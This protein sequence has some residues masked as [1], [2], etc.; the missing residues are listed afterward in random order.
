MSLDAIFLIGFMLLNLLVGILSSG[1]VKNM[2]EYAIGNRTFPTAVIVATIVATRIGGGDFSA[3]AAQSY[4]EGM[5]FILAAASGE[6][7][8]FLLIGYYLVPRMAEFFGMFTTAEILGNLYG[9]RVRMISSLCMMFLSLGVLA[10]QLKVS[11]GLLT[12]F[13]DI[14]SK[15][16]ILMVGTIVILYSAFGGIRAVTITDVLQFFTFGALLPIVSFVLWGTLGNP[17]VVVESIRHNDNYSLSRIF[18]LGNPKFYEMIMLFLLYL[19]PG[20]DVTMFQRF[21]MAQS[22]MQARRAFITSAMV[23]FFI[24]ALVSWIGTLLSVH[25]TDV[26]DQNIVGILIDNYGSEY[27]KV[28]VILGIMAMIMSTADSYMNAGSVVFVNDFCTSIGVKVPENRKIVV[29]KT[30]SVV[31]GICGIA[32]AFQEHGVFELLLLINSFSMPIDWV[33]L[34]L[35]IIGFRSSTRCVLIGMA[36]GLGTVASW[37]YIFPETQIAN[38]IPGVIA[39][40][41]FYIGSHYLF[42]EKGG[43]IGVRDRSCLDL[44]EAESKKS[45]VHDHWWQYITNFSFVRFCQKNTPKQD[46]IY[47]LLG[48]FSII[49]IFSSIYTVPHHIEVL[50]ADVME[51]IYN[52]VLVLSILMI[53]YP[54]WPDKLKNHEIS[55]VFRVCTVCYALVIAPSVLVF[56][57]NFGHLQAMIF[58]VNII[59]IAVVFNWRIVL[60]MIIIGL[61]CSIQWAKYQPDIAYNIDMGSVQLNIAYVAILL[62][63]IFVVLIRPKQEYR[64]VIETEVI[65]RTSQL[66]EALEEKNEFLNNMSHEI[67]TPL[68]SFTSI[69]SGLKEQWGSLDEEKKLYYAQQ[70][71]NSAKRLNSLIWSVL[72]LARFRSDTVTLEYSTFDF[73]ELV[74]ETLESVKGMGANEKHL[75]WKLSRDNSVVLEADKDSIKQ[76]LVHLLMNAIKFTKPSTTITVSVGFGEVDVGGS[77]VRAVHLSVADEGPGVPDEELEIIFQAFVQ[78]SRTKTKAGGIGLGLNLCKEIITAHHGAIWAEN[79]KGGVGATF[80][81]LVPLEFVLLRGGEKD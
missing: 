55:A 2:R 29:A 6:M 11:T 20:V 38:V 15:E 33:P 30:A 74:S 56:S 16:A 23:L 61:L 10:M 41:T 25:F 44:I 54:T 48:L 63:S 78:S 43:W 80:H 67:R 66:T 22:P 32:L 1:K 51:G 3:I 58:V 75:Q 9:N 68:H 27:F 39:N 7:L 8:A 13:F 69:A 35:A 64:E 14:P 46:Y 52:S 42:G 31:L 37:E 17:E 18:D 28:L 47:S 73:V 12:H 49:S 50:H 72:D 59:M 45:Q 62:S 77:F 65:K 60:S 5:Y 70:V 57:S 36:A 53:T 34:M 24:Y 4:S 79:N 19:A 71:S 21:S 26:N 81:I 40:A 76:V